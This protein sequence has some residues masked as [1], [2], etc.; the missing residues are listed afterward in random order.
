MLDKLHQKKARLGMLITYF[1]NLK[2]HLQTQGMKNGDKNM[3]K[4]AAN[5]SQ[6]LP[7]VRNAALSHY[8][9]FCVKRHVVAFY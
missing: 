1:K 4:F 7:E 6:I 9:S 5:L 2:A 8:L 3:Q